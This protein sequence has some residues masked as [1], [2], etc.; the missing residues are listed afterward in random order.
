MNSIDDVSTTLAEIEQIRERART[1]LRSIWYPLV[2]FGAASLGA[3][4][5]A[6]LDARWVSAYWLAAWVACFVAVGRY[7]AARGRR[8]G[9]HGDP[10]RRY[11]RL[12]LWS[13]PALFVVG[14]VAATLGGTP[15]AFAAVAG[16][17]G[18]S[19]LMIARWEHSALMAGLGL[20]V[21]ATG[22]V[23]AAT[24][25]A[26]LVALDNLCIGAVLVVGGL[27]ALSREATP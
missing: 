15:A 27:Y 9:I 12:W 22:A 6:G 17:V 3:A 23:L 7:Y 10:G 18:A 26:H 16:V 11:L 4:G 2:L 20:V 24:D 13:L 14:S 19:Y 1:G 25:P 21:A 8:V 5:V